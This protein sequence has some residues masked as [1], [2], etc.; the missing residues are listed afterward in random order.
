MMFV[1]TALP[2]TGDMSI[3]FYLQEFLMMKLE[4]VN[5]LLVITIT[6]VSLGCLLSAC[7]SKN[8]AERRHPRL[9]MVIVIT[10]K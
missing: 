3:S 5:H 10:N 6:I 9:T 8:E 2:K 1:K 7:D 4:K